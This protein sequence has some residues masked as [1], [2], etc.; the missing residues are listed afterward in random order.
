[1]AVIEVAVTDA[2]SRTVHWATPTETVL[3]NSPIPRG[4][5]HYGGTAAVAALG[6]GD[7]TNIDITLTF[8]PSF[9]YIPKTI[10]MQFT[11]DDLTTEFSNE[12]LLEYR[13]G[14]SATIGVREEFAMHC[15]GPTFRLAVNSV[16]VYR[17]LGTWR[18]VV[19]GNVQDS[20]HM[21][22]A[23]ISGD[24]STAGDVSWT[25]EFW[26]YDVEQCF[27]WPINTPV[28]TLNY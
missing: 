19:F 28:P 21:N 2:G 20:V 7:E 27:K 24:T 12:G 3:E 10:T 4:L 16:Q 13:P 9:V 23:D 1:M 17:P 25:A 11:S 26:E 6:A 15:D 8:P 18:L 14:G 5:R 22:M